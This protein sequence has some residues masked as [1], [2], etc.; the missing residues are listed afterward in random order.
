MRRNRIDADTIADVPDGYAAEP[1]TQY[2]GKDE[3]GATKLR[4]FG[5]PSSLAALII[6]AP[7][8]PIMVAGA[9]IGPE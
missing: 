3:A 5:R 1:V 4:T 9:L 6:S 8:P 2:V 7:R